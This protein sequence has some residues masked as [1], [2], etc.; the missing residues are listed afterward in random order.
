MSDGLCSES[1][2]RVERAHVRAGDTKQS[3]NGTSRK[4]DLKEDETEITDGG[5]NRD[6]A[7]EYEQTKEL[8]S[9]ASRTQPC[10]STELL[11][12]S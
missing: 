8:R 9:A 10:R 4:H 2:E 1:G 5:I 12:G 7:Q 11:S 6:E 3:S